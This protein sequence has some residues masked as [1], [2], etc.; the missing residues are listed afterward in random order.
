MTYPDPYN[1]RI[2]NPDDPWNRQWGGGSAIAEIVAIVIIAGIIA[3]GAHRTGTTT[4]TG[5]S[6]TISQPTTAGQ[7]GAPGPSKMVR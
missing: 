6:R 3:Y 2:S 1:D 7:G 5:Q 4:A